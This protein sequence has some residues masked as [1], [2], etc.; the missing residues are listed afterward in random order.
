M[1]HEGESRQCACGAV[2]RAD[3]K[4]QCLGCGRKAPVN[5]KFDM[6]LIVGVAVAI[7]LVGLILWGTSTS[8]DNSSPSSGGY[9]TLSE[10]SQRKLFYDL[11]STQDINPDSQAWNQA[12]KEAAAKSYSIPMSELNNIIHEGATNNW[13]TPHP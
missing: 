10:S 8:S 12:A 3:D 6:G 2:H 5:I 9:S 1:R 7:A 13:L 4:G 11:V